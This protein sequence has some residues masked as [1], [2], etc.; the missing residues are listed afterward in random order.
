[1]QFFCS[2]CSEHSHI[3]YFDENIWAIFNDERTSCDNII[4]IRV[5]VLKASIFVIPF[6]VRV[7]RILRLK[8]RTID[9]KK[10]SVRSFFL[11]PSLPL[12]LS[13]AQAHAILVEFKR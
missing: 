1:M 5:R 2:V 12:S 4:I 11:F 7:A 6:I 9:I 3:E 10:I 13:R 8:W